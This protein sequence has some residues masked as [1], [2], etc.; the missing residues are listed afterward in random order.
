MQGA[1]KAREA[2]KASEGTQAP[3]H[4]G[5]EGKDAWGALKAPAFKRSRAGVVG[6]TPPTA[7]ALP[8]GAEGGAGGLFRAGAAYNGGIENIGL[9][10][11]PGTGI[12]MRCVGRG[13]G[14]TRRR[15]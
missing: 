11:P 14:A 12:G 4:E 9:G 15:T 1:E 6:I 8:Q 7:R 2:T 5:T 10:A 13:A 3:R